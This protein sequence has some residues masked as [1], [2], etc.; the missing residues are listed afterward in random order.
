MCTHCKECRI[1]CLKHLTLA[2]PVS[3]YSAKMCL[4]SKHDTER[5]LGVIYLVSVYCRGIQRICTFKRKP[6]HRKSASCN[7]RTGAD[8][9]PT[10]TTIT[11]RWLW[12]ISVHAPLIRLLAKPA[13][14]TGSLLC[15]MTRDHGLQN[16]KEQT[17]L[18]TRPGTSKGKY[19]LKHAKMNP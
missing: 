5:T 3:P 9:P 16:A 13:L 6:F 7:S 12:P 15:E 11:T 8:P 17:S 2:Y 1:L 10:T 19:S 4:A 18:L 14:P